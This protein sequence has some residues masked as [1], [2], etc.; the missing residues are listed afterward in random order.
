MFGYV[1]PFHRDMKLWEWEGYRAAYCGLCDTIG[2][3]H[4]LPARM[5]LSYDFTLLA[6]LLLPPTPRPELGKCRCPARLWCR[7]KPCISPAPGMDTAADESVILAYWK[8]RDSVADEGFWK[9]QWARIAALVISPAYRRAERTCPA[10]AQ[11]VRECLGQLRAL[12]MENCASLDQSAD[13]FACMLQAAAPATGNPRQ[14][15]AVGQ[16]LYHVGRWIYLIDAWDDLEDDR[17]QGNYNPLLVRF[18]DGPEG[19]REE[20]AATLRHSLR[21]AGSALALLDLGGWQG[22]VE[23]ILTAGLPAVQNAIFNGRKLAP[24]RCFGTENWH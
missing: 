12:E 1:R 7:K 14:D 9:R 22:V 18:P 13:P 24:V 3:R 10:Y 5:F 4:G 17:T 11:T 15:R 19:H 2:R 21:L 6:M 23:N 20:V 16:L 8:L